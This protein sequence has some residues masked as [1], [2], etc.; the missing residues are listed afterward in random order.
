M[1]KFL[2]QEKFNSLKE[3]P[4]SWQKKPFNWSS[5]LSALVLGNALLWG[6]TLI[7]VQLI[8]LS[9]TSSG[10]ISIS[11]VGSQ[12]K[13][14]L[15]DSGEVG[16]GNDSPYQY[17]LKVDPRENYK[18]IALS[19]SVLQMAAS[20]LNMSL[21]DFGEPNLQSTEGTTIIQY[22]IEGISPTEARNKAQTFYQ[23]LSERVRYLRQ[24]ELSRQQVQTQGSLASAKRNL[25]NA[26][27]KLYEFTTNSPLKVSDQITQLSAQ[28]EEMRVEQANVLAQEKAAISR[29]KQ[30]SDN[31]NL[32]TKDASDALTLLDD[33]IFQKYL[34]QYSDSTTLLQSLSATLT[35][36]NPQVVEQKAL[37]AKA[38]TALKQRSRQLLGRP[39]S[40]QLFQKLNFSADGARQGIA[41]DLLQQKSEQKSLSAQASNLEQQIKR[42]S[43]RLQTL[44]QKQFTLD[45]LQQDVKLAESIFLSKS[46]Q[47]NVDQPDYATSYPPIQL[48]VE[49]SLPDEAD[50]S[51]RKTFLLGILAL[52]FIGSTGLLASWWNKNDDSEHD[53]LLEE[54]LFAD[55]FNKNLLE[56][57]S[58][59]DAVPPA[60]LAGLVPYN[61]NARLV[62]YNTNIDSNAI[63]PRELEELSLEQ[64][65]EKTNNLRQR[66]LY[67]KRAVEEQEEQVLLQSKI[68]NQ[69]EAD[70]KIASLEESSSHNGEDDFNQNGNL[71]PSPS[72]SQLRALL[73]E[74]TERKHLL[75][76]S[77]SV[78]SRYLNEQ[79]E[80]MLMYQRV[81]QE[82]LQEANEQSESSNTSN[83]AS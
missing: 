18:H 21:E 45:Q 19:K 4:Y 32:P 25:Q 50:S 15:P 67:I 58:Q 61:A 37:Q 17:L 38:Q 77:L 26:K 23:S 40:N 57:S 8:P 76:T 43:N 36:S 59:V 74:E 47:L 72:P 55:N 56:S 60:M 9:Y 42:L 22:D 11:G 7:M 71:R 70:L 48:V 1:N 51:K 66:W 30:T 39:I 53:G 83:N 31:L 6:L 68:I 13:V 12:G 64:L 28:L 35:A 49:P 29:A 78:Q 75:E 69:L 54:E 41:T 14:L 44:T 73:M 62:P 27:Q 24:D 81:L 5:R 80:G 63:Q 33:Q 20:S 82:R 2:I 65:Q 79:Q 16:K 10:S 34:Q 46:A 52:S 3:T